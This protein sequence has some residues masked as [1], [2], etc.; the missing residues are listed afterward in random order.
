LKIFLF[1]HYKIADGFSLINAYGIRYI[2]VSNSDYKDLPE[3]ILMHCFDSVVVSEVKSINLD[4]LKEWFKAYEKSNPSD[5]LRIKKLLDENID[6]CNLLVIGAKLEPGDVHQAHYHEHETVI[7]FGLRGKA[8]ATVDGKDI[9]VTQDTL[10]YIPPMI[11]HKFANNSEQAWE[12]VAI[13]I[14]PKDA[15]LENIWVNRP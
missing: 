7:V 2:F 5:M 13:A 6:S 8:V 4:D 11:V 10:V 15:K 1:A 14:G 12:C 9:E 3:K